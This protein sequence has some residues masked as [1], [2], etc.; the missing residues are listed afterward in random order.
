[1][2]AAPS[3]TVAS[4]AWHHLRA[5][6]RAVGTMLALALLLAG[7]AVLPPLLVA[8]AVDGAIA[9]RLD[10]RAALILALGVAALAAADF[11]LTLLRRRLAVA[12]EMAV[13]AGAARDRFR[14]SLHQPLAAYGMG[15]EAALIRAF[16]DLDTLVEFVAA[17]T[18]EMAAEIVLIAAYAALLLSVHPVLALAFLALAG[19]GFAV[20]LWL[21]AATH[22][23]CDAWLPLRDRRFGL[24][25]DV[26]S[27]MLAVKALGAQSRLE[28]PF[29]AAHDAEAAALRIWRLATARA[30]AAGRF[31][32][33]ATPG[34]GA[35][36]GAAM[37]AHGSLPV[38]A[39]MLFLAVSAGLAGALSALNGNLQEMAHAQ[40]AATRLATLATADSPAPDGARSD[41]APARLTA[42][43]LAFRHDPAAPDVLSDLDLTLPPGA[44]IALVG[45]SGEGKTTL[46]LLLARLLDPDQGRIALDDA[47]PLP[48]AQ[49]RDRVVLVPHLT[50][51]FSVSLREN[52]R[53]W[54]TTI[55]DARIHQALVAARLDTVVQSWPA[56]LDTPLGAH[57]APLS[58][59][60]LQRLGLARALLRRPA[61]L[62]LDEA[63]SALDSETE[64]A[65]LANLRHLM[66]G[67]GMIVIT[68]RATVA[69][70]F[71]R[72]LHLR[73][74]RLGEL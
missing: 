16:D 67:R 63:T 22:R 20:A 46:A 12:N 56:G 54:D 26:L 72:T 10:A 51:L 32:A 59:G 37:L 68:H 62:I 39:L 2:T 58:A 14:A 69:A 29:A 33:V 55:D 70:T 8:H 17:R 65:I 71:D 25:V 38:A 48:A 52:I 19:S 5:R 66:T 6:P 53:L 7:L 50:S 47:P 9:G 4:L 64:T 28:Q 57:G 21:A 41:A 13:R 42:E 36:L 34:I 44:H 31:F 61:V 45:P 43:H 40:S 27:A 24:I 15:R 23:A 3:S 30:E 74:G 73:G 11:A 18:V 60:Q 1:M 49:H 35:A